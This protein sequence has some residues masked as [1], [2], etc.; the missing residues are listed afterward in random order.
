MNIKDIKRGSVIYKKEP[1]T[2]HSR[3]FLIGRKV[4]LIAHDEIG[5]EFAVRVMTGAEK[6]DII[7]LV[8]KLD[9]WDKGWDLWKNRDS[10]GRS[11]FRSVIR[12]FTWKRS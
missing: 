6:D 3:N 7:K 10:K 2:L 12:F 9:R 8:Y 11:L 4:R 1:S 5:K